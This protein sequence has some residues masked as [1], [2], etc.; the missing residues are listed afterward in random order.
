MAECL[1]QTEISHGTLRNKGYHTASH[2]TR[3]EKLSDILRIGRY[4]TNLRCI[5][6]STTR[7]LI[8]LLT[9]KDAIFSH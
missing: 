1:S 5:Q 8:P 2:N 4:N 7:L 6:F 9:D 3:H